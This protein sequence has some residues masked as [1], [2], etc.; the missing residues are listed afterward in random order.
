MLSSRSAPRLL[1][2]ANSLWNLQN[3]R[4]GLLRG[5]AAAGFEPVLAAPPGNQGHALPF[6]AA[7]LPISS[8]GLNPLQDGLL[9]L[10][11][12]RL[13]RRERPAAL[14]SWTAKPNIY[15]AMAARQ[16]GVPAFPNVS[17]LGTAFIRGGMLQRVLCLLYRTAFGRC[18]A[19]FFQNAEDAELFVDLRLVRPDQVRLLPGSGVDLARF[20]A[21][22]IPPIDGPLRLLF[23]GRLL[24]DKGVRELAAAAR[25]LKDEGTPVRFQLL[26]VLGAQNRTAITRAELDGWLAE[27]LLDY[28]GVADDV[29]PALAQAHAV[30]LPSYREGLPRSLLEAA[31]SG[32]PLL[33]SDVPG[34]RDVVEDR[35]NGLLFP[36]R[37]AE[38]LAKAV[39]DY[40]ALTPA[41]QQT[42]GDCARRTVEQRFGEDRVIA[43]YLREI[44]HLLEGGEDREQ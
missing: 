28:L 24:G 41:E 11:F 42:M 7:S 22:P 6:R 37:S 23:V 40:L 12:I 32:R 18:P 26:G 9:L 16:V 3:F 17:G 13:L 19:V 31:A 1:A 35:V 27:D 4:G 15:G 5:V 14:I 25:L 39:R 34:C 29:R 38:G 2:S 30:I 43:A 44:G 10:R 36:V 33:A 21:V 8:D 20:P